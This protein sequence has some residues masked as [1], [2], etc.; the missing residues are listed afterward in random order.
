MLA[1]FPAFS[2]ERSIGRLGKTS[3]R[4]VY[5]DLSGTRDTADVRLLHADAVLTDH[6]RMTK[7][8]EE[9]PIGLDGPSDVVPCLPPLRQPHRGTAQHL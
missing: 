7:R 3:I 2:I 6:A 9:R 1:R 8:I 4:P 5:L